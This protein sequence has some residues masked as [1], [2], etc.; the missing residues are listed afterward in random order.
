LNSG[1]EI[2]LA[3]NNK[4]YRAI[5]TDGMFNI[6]HG[7]RSLTFAPGSSG[8][9]DPFMEISVRGDNAAALFGNPPVEEKILI[10]MHPNI[11]E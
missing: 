1:D 9:D 5:F 11:S 7:H 8:Y 4:T 10:R 3:I 6:P 2:A